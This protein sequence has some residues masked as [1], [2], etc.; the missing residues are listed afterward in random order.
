MRVYHD[1]EF[2]EKNNSV[3]PISVGMVR[4][5]GKSLYYEFAEAPWT[6]VLKH[7]W[8]K[9]YVV[10]LLTCANDGSLVK[11][12]GTLTFKSTLVIRSKVQEFLS[13]AHFDG[14]GKLELWGWYSGYDHVCLGQL[15]GAMINLPSF[16]PMWTN[17][18]RQEVHRLGNL[19]IPDFREPGEL[20]HHALDDAKAEMRMHNWLIELESEK[21]V[22]IAN[23][24][25]IQYGNGNSQIN[26]F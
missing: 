22:R 19:R 4:E 21:N 1:W 16:I 13:R 18:I 8:L 24:R 23:S 7:D 6:E 2:L 5:D 10:P 20:V 12:E 15:F 11:M 3:Y 14:G 25:G 17:D 9:T 26:T